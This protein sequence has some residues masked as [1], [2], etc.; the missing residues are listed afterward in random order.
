MD[1]H[2]LEDLETKIEHRL[3][4]IADALDRTFTD[5]IASTDKADDLVDAA[6]ED[7]DQ[8]LKL[9]VKALSDLI[10]S[11]FKAHQRFSALS[12]EQIVSLLLCDRDADDQHDAFVDLVDTAISCS[13]IKPSFGPVMPAGTIAS[14]PVGE[15]TYTNDVASFPDLANLIAQLPE[16]HELRMDVVRVYGYPCDRACLVLDPREFLS[17]YEDEINSLLLDQNIQEVLS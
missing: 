3:R 16:D 14:I 11:D 2:H 1:P 12:G 8:T 9:T 17:H 7:A 15:T 5:G 10:A 13:D 4:S 6:I